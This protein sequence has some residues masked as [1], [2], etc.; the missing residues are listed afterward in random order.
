MGLQFSVDKAIEPLLRL[1]CY[2]STFKL[3]RTLWQLFPNSIRLTCYDKLMRF[4]ISITPFAA[5]VKLPC[6]LA[7]KRVSCS[8]FPEADNMD[9]VAA[10]TSLPVP[11]VLDAVENKTP[12]PYGYILMTWIE[13]ETLGKWTKAHERASPER[14]AA[15]AAV[16]AALDTDDMS[17][18]EVAVAK[19]QSLPLPTLDLSDADGLIDDLRRSLAELRALPSP[20]GAVTR[21]RGRELITWRTGLE[22]MG[23]FASQEEFKDY[24]V[25]RT[26]PMVAHRLPALRRLAAPVR[27]KQHRI[28]F[29]HADLHGANILVKDN[30]LAGIVDWEHAGWYPEY[31]EMTMMERLHMAQPLMQQ[32]WDVVYPDWVEKYQDELT[33]ESA[34]WKCAGDTILVDD[35]GDDFTCTR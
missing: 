9:F 2:V 14:V 17:V 24:L 11:R 12:N 34:L 31:W 21:L 13:G 28:C 19:L 33:L 35:I 7:L 6:D 27:A 20:S 8:P 5:V 32:F 15:V 22:T 18:L 3:T 26:S 1:L 10:H 4:G 23:P 30:R 29:T 25:Y 16:N